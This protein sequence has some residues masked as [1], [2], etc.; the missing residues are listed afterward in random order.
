MGEDFMLGFEVRIIDRRLYVKKIQ[1][2]PITGESWTDRQL[3]YV[4]PE[5]LRAQREFVRTTTSGEFTVSW[6][7]HAGRLLYLSTYNL[8]RH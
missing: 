4:G 1:G 7:I 8:L 6:K 3:A 5:R 2:L